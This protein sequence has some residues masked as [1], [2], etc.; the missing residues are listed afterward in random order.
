M[1]QRLAEIFAGF[2]RQ[3]MPTPFA[4]AIILTGLVFGL[5][6]ALTP[7][8]PMQMVDYWYDG[9]WGLLRFT[10]QMVAILLFGY[11][12]A[13]APPMKRAILA[14][15][16]LPKSATGVVAMVCAL[17]ISLSFLNWGLGL[18]VG[19]V[20]AREFCRQAR[21]RGIQVH[22]PLTVAAGF[23][24]GTTSQGGLTSSASLLVN[25]EGHFLADQIG[26]IPLVETIFSPLNLI[27]GATFMILLP[28]AAARMHPAEKVREISDREAGLDADDAPEDEPV[29]ATAPGKASLS[30]AAVP[31]T[32]PTVAERIENSRILTGVILAIGFTY[33]GNFILQ[34]GLDLNL[35]VLNL[36]F[37]LLG[38][39][40]YGTPIAYVRAIDRGIRTCSQI[41]LQFPFYAGIMGM[42]S[43]SGLLALFASGLA[44][45]SN[46]YT[47]PFTSMLSSAFVNLMVPSN[48]G[49]WAVQGPMLVEAAHMLEADISTV[50]MAF[51]YGDQLTNGIQP[52]WMLPLLGVTALKARDILGY[53]A[54]LMLVSFAVVSIALLTLPAVFA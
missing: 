37:L 25:T 2:A 26:L 46:A 33:V 22:Y 38:L 30:A 11:V 18:I 49:Q 9:F 42:M 34:N 20:A 13:E 12:F 19:A 1:L 41:I 5:G 54:A 35:N 40:A 44:S 36:T 21:D 6:V 51:S 50:V 52:M 3:F 32:A 24:G 4:F 15:G 8:S 14:L 45:I 7:S 48:G 16:S 28:V 39:L 23:A 31:E 43:A 29:V 17:S 10:T 27:V 47:L 53:T